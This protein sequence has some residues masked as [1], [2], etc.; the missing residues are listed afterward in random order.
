VALTPGIDLSSSA[1]RHREVA[2]RVGSR[3]ARSPYADAVLA[4]LT[5]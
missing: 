3:N 4:P 1:D 5:N 2:I